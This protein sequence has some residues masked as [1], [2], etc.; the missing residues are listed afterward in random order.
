MKIM[1]QCIIVNEISCFVAG[2]EVM[3]LCRLTRH[4]AAV[5]NMQAYKT[6]AI[7]PS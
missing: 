4:V 1:S 3:L 7:N 5:V 2:L 6:N